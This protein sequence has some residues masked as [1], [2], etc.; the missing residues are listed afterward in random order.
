MGTTVWH[1]VS[2]CC[3]LV[4]IVQALRSWIGSLGPSAIS[5]CPE[6]DSWI[7]DEFFEVETLLWYDHGIYNKL[8]KAS[9]IYLLLARLIRYAWT[10]LKW[11]LGYVL[12]PCYQ[13]DMTKP[14]FIA[15]AIV[16]F[17]PNSNILTNLPACDTWLAWRW[18]STWP[19]SACRLQSCSEQQPLWIDSKSCSASRYFK[20]TL[21]KKWT[22]TCTPSARSLSTMGTS[23]SSRLV[24]VRVF[25][26]PL[27]IMDQV[28]VSHWGRTAA[29]NDTYN[30]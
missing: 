25:D 23:S 26:I 17:A 28:S 18:Y 7:S 1:S 8:K 27:R 3:H 19:T 16:A 29:E 22:K 5:D 20:R 30:R 11:K 14:Q 12:I 9:L 4:Y 21:G 2:G 13:A 24:S 6:F 10:K 15:E